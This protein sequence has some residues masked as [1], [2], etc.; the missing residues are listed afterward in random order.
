MEN[1]FTPKINVFRERNNFYAASQQEG[2]SIADFMAR[3][4]NLST[5]CNFGDKLEGILIDKFVFGFKSGKIKDR[6]CEEK[7]TVE[8]TFSQIVDC[9]GKRNLFIF[10]G[11]KGA[12]DTG[13]H[14]AQ[15]HGHFQSKGSSKN[16]KGKNQEINTVPEN[17]ICRVCGKQH[18]GIQNCKYKN[19]RCNLCG[20]IGHLA[21]MCNKPKSTNF[22]N[23]ESVDDGTH[24]S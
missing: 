10:H 17:N 12:N 13:D 16:F 8:T 7:P 23:V 9:T 20:T 22:L 1:H 18:R 5:N 2:E 14:G 4:R 21:K 24:E 3:L 11:D 19:Y 15:K 6:I